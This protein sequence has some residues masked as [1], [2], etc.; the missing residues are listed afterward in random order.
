MIISKIK[1]RNNFFFLFKSRLFLIYILF[2]FFIISLV[3]PL[4]LQKKIA[5]IYFEGILEIR[6]S[7]GKIVNNFINFSNKNFSVFEIDKLYL[8]INQKNIFTLHK[9]QENVLNRE[10]FGMGYDFTNVN[11]NIT[12]EEKKYSARL[13]LKGDTKDHFKNNQWS[14]RVKIKDEKKFDGMKIF[15][16]HHAKHRNYFYEWFFL[17]TLKKENVIAPKYKFMELILNGESLGVYAVEEH[18][19]KEILES[20][21]RR[22]GPIIRF[23]ENFYPN[24]L[25]ETWNLDDYELVSNQVK[26]PHFLFNFSQLDSFENI[27]SQNYNKNS[28]SFINCKKLFEK[29]RSGQLSFD[30]VFDTDLITKHAAL[31]FIFGA[32]HGLDINNQR[33][34]CNTF[35]NKI[36]PIG[37]DG[38]AGLVIMRPSEFYLRI[39]TLLGSNTNLKFYKKLI[40]NLDKYSNDKF[41]DNLINENEFINELKKNVNI[42][43]SDFSIDGRENYSIFKNYISIIENL[44]NKTSI[45]HQNQK[46]IRSLINP[47]DSIHA[48][49]IGVKDN[50]IK[51]KFSNSH[52]LPIEISN[53][54]IDGDK[55]NSYNYIIEGAN[56]EFPF[57]KE[58]NKSI[59]VKLKIKNKKIIDNIQGII[60][61]ILDEDEIININFEY[62]I[63]GL[64]KDKHSSKIVSVN[65]YSKKLFRLENAID[66]IRYLPEDKYLLSNNKII[67][68]DDVSFNKPVI[69]PENFNILI[70]PGVNINLENSAYL[71]I[72]SNIELIGTSDNP[73]SI[74]NHNQSGLGIIITGNN[75][76]SIFNNVVVSG[77]SNLDYDFTSGLNITGGITFYN[78]N[79]F[80]NNVLMSSNIKGDDLINI[81]GSK[82][83]IENSKFQNSFADSLDIDFSNGI[84]K[85]SSFKNC[86]ITKDNISKNLMSNGDCV[87]FSGSNVKLENIIIENAGDKAISVGENSN[88][89]ISHIK[90][91]NAKYGLVSKDNSILKAQ[92]ISIDNAEYGFAS[93]K[94]KEEFGPG[95]IISKRVTN[96]SNIKNTFFSDNK[97]MIEVEGLFIPNNYL[98]FCKKIKYE[99]DYSCSIYN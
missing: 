4:G 77:L 52:P 67:I 13:R 64:T 19:S 94:K 38:D 61:S 63:A 21:Q 8:D 10:Y 17:K 56:Y 14:F 33:F 36:E 54:S 53:I 57:N 91:K 46:V 87:D 42:T 85:K 31:A 86:G 22:E 34:Y 75:K 23:E 59:V 20:N 44:E 79:V 73:I 28:M 65:D 2:I 96:L 43:L 27:S 95:K 89:N 81:F 70:K 15:S 24:F 58:K 39:N 51:I 45:I 98:D 88:V 41:I 66:L 71:L 11:A 68:T 3:S 92:Y 93:Y 32:T 99:E 30:Q 35:N 12:F 76:Q 78:T 7:L 37:F 6:Y 1:K 74:T 84:I 5:D 29:Y 80:L 25:M 40:Q 18:F 90:I 60:N 69:F 47:K 26:W 50:I 97:S 9:D 48:E 72:K 55:K 82:F 83:V 16:L 62:N 49:I